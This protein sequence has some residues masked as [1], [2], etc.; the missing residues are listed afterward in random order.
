[1]TKS[2][3]CGWRGDIL[4]ST[5]RRSSTETVLGH[6]ADAGVDFVGV[7][8]GL[9]VALAGDGLA[10]RDA[11]GG[12]AAHVQLPEGLVGGPAGGVEVVDEVDDLVLH[13]LEAADGGAELDAGAA[14]VDGDLVDGLAAADLV[15]ADDRDGLGDGALPRGPAAG[16]GVPRG[17]WWSDGPP[18]T[19]AATLSKRT[20]A[21]FQ[22]KPGRLRA[23]TPG[24]SAGTT[25]EANVLGLLRSGRRTR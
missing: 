15:G 20:S 7:V 21:R 2:G 18:R 8:A 12:V 14:V 22:A 13:A 11:A 9:V 1:M 5:V 17:R 25:T 10:Q 19:F 24:A 3:W 16:D 23:R 6:A 4:L